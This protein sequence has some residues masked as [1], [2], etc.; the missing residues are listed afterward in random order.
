MPKCP[1]CGRETLRT[2]DW[3]CQ[4]CG[5]PLLSGAFRKIPK[6]YREIQEEKSAKAQ[7]IFE[8]RP[9]P[10]PVAEVAVK[11]VRAPEPEPQPPPMPEPEPEMEPE[12]PAPPQPAAAVAAEVEEEREPLPPLEP[13]AE[14][15]EDSEAAVEPEKSS[16]PEAEAEPAPE[17]VTAPEPEAE[18]A[19]EPAAESEPEIEAVP[20]P[21]PVAVPALE[22]DPA[23][24]TINAT[25]AG[26]NAAFNSD[27]AGTNTKLMNK[28]LQVAGTVDKVFVRDNL[29]IFYIMLA[30]VGNPSSWQVRCTFDREHSAPL[31]RLADGQAATVQG[32]YAGYERNIILK[33]CSLVP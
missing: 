23:T 21:E 32:T 25:V 16:V 2:E 20:A 19:P 11:P 28:P 24:G 1:N 17:P 22:P 15:V 4:W 12:T 5:H 31:S 8:E 10:S 9:E 14:T 13:E 33:D 29:D 18:P 7:P 6:T 3:A 27:K 30:D 26:L